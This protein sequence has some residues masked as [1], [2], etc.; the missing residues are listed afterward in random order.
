VSST[1]WVGAG[2]PVISFL[3]TL[4]FFALCATSARAQSLPSCNPLDYQYQVTDGAQDFVVTSGDIVIATQLHV[5]KPGGITIS[6]PGRIVIIGAIFIADKTSLT[7]NGGSVDQ[8][9]CYPKHPVTCDNSD[10]P[11][12]GNGAS[13]SGGILNLNVGFGGVGL[14]S[15]PFRQLIIKDIQYIYVVAPS[16]TETACLFVGKHSPRVRRTELEIDIASAGFFGALQPA[17]VRSLGLNNSHA[18][19]G[20]GYQNCGTTSYPTKAARR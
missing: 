12:E 20:A 17:L 11:G 18:W 19:I 10:N 8:V 6:T 1:T 4:L 3:G 2:R 14:N 7:L 13:I 5:T 9:D 16:P 15:C